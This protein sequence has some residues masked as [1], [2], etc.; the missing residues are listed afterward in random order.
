MNLET[1]EG[2]QA[3]HSFRW[4]CSP[5]LR[6]ASVSLAIPLTEASAQEQDNVIYLKV[7]WPV[8]RSGRIRA[9]RCVFLLL[10]DGAVAQPFH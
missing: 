3:S 8:A 6:S 9:S 4:A 7:K 5:P 1:L 2:F 10:S